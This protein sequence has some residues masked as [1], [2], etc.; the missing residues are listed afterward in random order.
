MVWICGSRVELIW[1]VGF[2]RRGR[3]TAN[4]LDVAR[5]MPRAR[6]LLRFAVEPLGIEVLPALL[7]AERALA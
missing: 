7:A 3:P 4:R 2:D 5:Y 1:E 6:P